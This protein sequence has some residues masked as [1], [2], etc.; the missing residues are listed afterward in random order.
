MAVIYFKSERID[1]FEW[2][3]DGHWLAA[4]RGSETSD[5]VLL[6]PTSE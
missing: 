5:V 1:S 2:S 4:V 3:P 6:Q